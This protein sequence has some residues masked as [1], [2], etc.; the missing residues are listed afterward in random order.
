MRIWISIAFSLYVCAAAADSGQAVIARWAGQP[1][2]ASDVESASSAL[3]AEHRASFSSELRQLQARQAREYHELLARELERLLDRRALDMEVAARD[4]SAEKLLSQ[5][6][7]APVTDVEVRAFYAAN[8]A[9]IGEPYEQAEAEIREHLVSQHTT[10]ATR[11]FYDRL[12]QRHEIHSGLQPHREQVNATGASVGPADA[13][14]TIVEFA[15]FQCPYCA[16]SASVLKSLRT[17][18]GDRLRL[19]FRHLPLVD[20]HPSALSAARAAVCA[21][22]QGKFWAMHEAM[23]GNQNALD[24]AALENTARKL[25]LNSDRYARCVAEDATTRQIDADAN[26]A[27][28]LG[29]S[30]T[31]SFLING[32]LI[33]GSPPEGE[34]TA[35]IEDELR[36]TDQANPRSRAAILSGR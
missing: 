10:A 24:P 5:I 23:Y 29:I 13:P 6:D 17:K 8:R 32:R 4:V 33:V 7:V 27:F 34:L 25:G 3:F 11:A 15:D 12:R 20:I 21:D 30:S 16:Q 35:L 28:E 22:Q 26:A 14:V 18:Y 19:V 1:I 31:P 36:R 2:T 9:R